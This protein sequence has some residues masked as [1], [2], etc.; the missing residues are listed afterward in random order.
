MEAGAALRPAEARQ[1]RA[2]A[3]ARRT[4]RRRGPAA[5]RA[6]STRRPVRRARRRRALAAS[7]RRAPG[8][9][10]RAAPRRGAGR[11]AGSGVAGNDAWYALDATLS[12]PVERDRVGADPSLGSIRRLDPEMILGEREQAQRKLH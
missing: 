2:R 11:T 3:R 4:R 7:A 6:G 9:R 8:R 12:S 1:A 10:T 5:P